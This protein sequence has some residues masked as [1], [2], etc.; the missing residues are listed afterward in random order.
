VDKDKDKDKG[1]DM[2]GTVAV[3]RE[4]EV[5]GGLLEF[6]NIPHNGDLE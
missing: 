2:P 4:D 3:A 6:S 1:V 5:K